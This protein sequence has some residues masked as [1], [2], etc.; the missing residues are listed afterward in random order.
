M[1]ILGMVLVLILAFIISGLSF[2]LMLAFERWRPNTGAGAVVDAWQRL[3][4]GGGPGKVVHDLKNLTTELFRADAQ[5]F[6]KA[7]CFAV[8]ILSVLACL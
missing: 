8:L 1:R 3:A 5:Y 7:A 4:A 6:S 2:P